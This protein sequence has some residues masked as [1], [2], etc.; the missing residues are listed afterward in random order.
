M[1]SSDCWMSVA[2]VLVTFEQATL[3]AY[4][5]KYVDASW[6]HSYG[7]DRF[8]NLIYSVPTA[9]EMRQLTELAH[10][11]GVGWLYVT[12][13]GPDGNPWD[14]PATYLTAEAKLWT[15]VE[16]S[17][18]SAPRR[19]S[20]QWSGL[21]G[22]RAQ[23]LMDSG[24]KGAN[25][26]RGV[27]SGLEADLMLEIP[28]DGSV[29]LMRYAGS[30]QDWKWNVQDANPVLSQPQPGTNRVEL[31]AVPLGTAPDIKIQFRLLDKDWNA[32]SASKILDWKP[33]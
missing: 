15:G 7:P 6:T 27:G 8:W 2:D 32:M 23:I 12:D 9:Q 21:K 28:G 17:V 5:S 18:P 13:D 30:G 29:R 3:A 4:Q 22:S 24:Q 20:I 10:R 26:Y 31:D 1:P 14:K 11:R 19:V 25:R 16:P 33:I